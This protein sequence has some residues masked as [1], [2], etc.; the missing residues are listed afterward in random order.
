MNETEPMEIEPEANAPVYR[1]PHCDSVVEPTATH[2]LMCGRKL[3]V[4]QLVV[5]EDGGLRADEVQWADDNPPPADSEPQKVTHDLSQA[6]EAVAETP[7]ASTPPTPRNRQTIVFWGLT[8]VCALITLTLSA[9]VLRYP[10]PRQAWVFIAT[11]TPIPPTATATPV[12]TPLPSETPFPSET[13]TIT[14]TPRPTDTPQPPRFHA[15]AAG[16]TL[17][18]LSVRYRVSAESIA[19]S[20]NMGLDSPIQAGQNL[21]IPWPTPTPDLPYIPIEINGEVV[22][23]VAQNCEYYQVQADDTAFGIAARYDIPI[24]ALLAVNWHTTESIALLQPGD[25][26]CIPGVEYDLRL[27]PPTPGPSP[28]PQP[29]AAAA[30]PELLYPVAGTV[31]EDVKTAVL[32]QWVAVKDLAPDEWYMVELTDD[33]D[34]DAIAFRGFTRDNSFRLPGSWR[35][36]TPELRPMRWRVAIVRVTGERT[37]GRFIYT[38]GGNASDPAWFT[39][40]GAIPTATPTATVTPTA[41]FTP[42]P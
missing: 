10:A 40:L 20:N 42:T 30:G 6:V 14:P 35:P 24:E 16:E 37:D 9:F 8:A 17:I 32:L 7:A 18:G 36:T 41:T 25:V 19:A 22:L 13:P 31:V 2:C 3:A 4:A 34:L 38:F 1:C 26:L 21:E 27:L 5:D 15:I 39:W 33:D 28:T 23:A 12:W 11:A 29:T